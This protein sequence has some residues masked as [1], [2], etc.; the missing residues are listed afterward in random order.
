MSKDIEDFYIEAKGVEYKTIDERKEK[1]FSYYDMIGFT[2][3]YIS[4][5]R[6]QSVWVV[7]HIE[8]GVIHGIFLEEEKAKSFTD[9]SDN[10]IAIK[11]EVK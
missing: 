5:N 1:N 4:K 8:T 7:Q 6:E 2:G 10:V 9:G 3:A 11:R